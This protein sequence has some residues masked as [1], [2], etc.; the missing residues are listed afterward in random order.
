MMFKENLNESRPFEHPPVREKTHQSKR[1]GGIIGCKDKT[2]SWHLVG[3]P[4]Y[5]NI[6]STVSC[7]EE[8]HSCTVYTYTN[9]H[10]GT[11]DKTK[12]KDTM[13]LVVDYNLLHWIYYTR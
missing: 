9:R 5:G 11:P 3:F 2:S 6:W 12:T 13:S 10:A 8:A 1:S 4:K 7:R